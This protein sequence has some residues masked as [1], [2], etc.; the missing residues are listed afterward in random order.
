MVTGW[1]DLGGNRYYMDTDG[2][3]V[4]GWVAV[5]GKRYYM[6]AAGH[7]VTGWQNVGDKWYYLDSNGQMVTGWQKLVSAGESDWYY[8]NPGDDGYM[9]QSTSRA[10]GSLTYAFDSKGRMAEMDNGTF[11]FTVKNNLAGVIVKQYK[12]NESSVTVP[13]TCSGITVNE[14]GEEAFMGK[15]LT[16]IDLPDSI[17]VIGARAF[18]NCSSLSSMN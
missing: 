18:K 14:I 8:F 2:H 3:M 4:T 10:I 17:Q 13:G 9:L 7:M 1:K 15:S 5:D 6:D 16:S 12:G 11:V